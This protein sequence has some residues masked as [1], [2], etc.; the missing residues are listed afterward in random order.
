ML[1]LKDIVSSWLQDNYIEHY[2]VSCH[3]D[4]IRIY[5]YR[6]IDIDTTKV[7]CYWWRWTPNKRM[8][9]SIIHSADPEFFEKLHEFIE[10]R[11]KI[12]VA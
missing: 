8:E 9:E 2:P 6:I 11:L 10:W 4:T 5:G 7:V 1:T 12:G 3:E